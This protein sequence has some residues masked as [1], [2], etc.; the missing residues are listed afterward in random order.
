ML[1]RDVESHCSAAHRELL[2]RINNLAAKIAIADSSGIDETLAFL[3][4]SLEIDGDV[5]T[6]EKR[7]GIYIARLYSAPLKIKGRFIVPKGY[8]AQ[9]MQLIAKKDDLGARVALTTAIKYKNER[10]AQ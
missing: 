1:Q 2:A 6:F 3:P 8:Y 9:G 10:D 5:S 4:E 7:R